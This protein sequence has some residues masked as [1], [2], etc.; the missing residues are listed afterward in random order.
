[1][2]DRE[3]Q[4]TCVPRFNWFLWIAVTTLIQVKNQIHCVYVLRAV[5]ESRLI[6]TSLK[7]T[8]YS[9]PP[10]VLD[11]SL[12]PP[13]NSLLLHS[14]FFVSLFLSFCFIENDND[15]ASEGVE[16]KSSNQ[17]RLFHVI[18]H[19]IIILILLSLYKLTTNLL[20]QQLLI[21]YSR[22]VKKNSFNTQCFKQYRP[23]GPSGK[24]LWT[25]FH[26]R[27]TTLNGTIIRWQF[28]GQPACV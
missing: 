21:S 22:N 2:K 27:R 10:L 4:K 13:L 5:D 12:C 25:E 18:S 6:G 16:V 19:M 11:Y 9:T 26:I 15:L 1:M 24:F 14:Y 28:K 23:R 3:N 7:Y 20:K 17:K 8:I